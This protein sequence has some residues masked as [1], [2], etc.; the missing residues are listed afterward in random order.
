MK[1]TVLVCAH[2]EED[3]IGNC[4]NSLMSMEIPRGMIVD[5]F[6]V[7]DRCSDRTKQIAEKM[8]VSMIEK[9]FRGGYVSPIAEAVAYGIETTNGELILICDADIQE[10]PQDALLRLLPHLTDEVRRVSSEV[11]TRSGKWWLDFL[12]WLM[13]FNRKI[14]P[15]GAEP[16]GAF[17]IFE[18]Q[19]VEKIGG[20]DPNKP[21]WDT[22][23]DSKIKEKGW[24]V[25]RVWDVV[26]TEKR[27]FT[28]DR[29][30]TH[31]IND[32]KARRQLHMSFLRTLLHSTFRLRPFV[33]HGYVQQVWREKFG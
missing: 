15:L 26:V 25:K 32:G 11:K 33:L 22:A 18:R 12:F 1:L 5:Y 9:N 27:P 29:L 28:V 16:R 30:I 20:F 21:T 17:T 31:Q 10:I 3:V 24:K 2:N 19:T 14:T 4:L 7:L 23:F 8:G 6:T 13:G